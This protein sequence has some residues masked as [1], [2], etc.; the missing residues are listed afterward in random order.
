MRD[1]F[2]IRI[3][4][5]IFG[6]NVWQIGFYRRTTSQPVHIFL[7]HPIILF[8]FIG[9]FAAVPSQI[10]SITTI[11]RKKIGR[12][13][14]WTEFEF[15]LRRY[16][17]IPTDCQSNFLLLLLQH[18]SDI[19]IL[20]YQSRFFPRSS[21]IRL[22]LLLYESKTMDKREQ[23]DRKADKKLVGLY[24]NKSRLDFPLHSRFLVFSPDVDLATGGQEGEVPLSVLGIGNHH[25]LETRHAL[26]RGNVQPEQ[27]GR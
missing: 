25:T 2:F 1:T 10:D 11:S 24:W 7:C 8:S 23:Y 6:E 17:E 9:C 20:Y 3:S 18:F 12:E 13:A 26:S 21:H 14:F 27:S 19:K 15:Y 22:D 4:G 5:L 16:D